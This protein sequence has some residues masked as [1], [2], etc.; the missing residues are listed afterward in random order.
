MRFKDKVALVTGAG[1]GIGA[2]TARRLASE[3]AH[4]VLLDFNGDGAAA[5]A[6]A[7]AADGGSGGTSIET[8]DVSDWDSVSGAFSRI[9]EKHPKL[10]ILVNNAG[11]GLLGKAPDVPIADWDR[12]LGVVLNG[13]FYC[14]KLG[15]PLLRVAGG[16]AI[17]NVASIAG[18]AGEFH[19][20][21]YSAAK[22]GV[23]NFTRAVAI[24]HI[25]E[26]IRVN[27]V[28]PG[29]VDT[30]AAKMLKDNAPLW[31][32]IQDSIPSGR[33][34][35]PSEI[36]AVIAFLASDDASAMVGSAVVVD[37]GITAW[38]GSPNILG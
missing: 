38:T 18:M 5:T 1:S 8:A 29:M 34:A 17:V 11:M 15:I 30:P 22:G 6:A 24:D 21:A 16:G 10:D 2:A 32:R 19:L 3:G 23:L 33:P 36:A 7:I 26:G 14:T 35:Q 9:A 13:V 27:A 4:V 31:E 12:V 25:K 28:C 20:P 37:N